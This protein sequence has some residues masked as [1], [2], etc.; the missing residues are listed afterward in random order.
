M[1][2]QLMFNNLKL[3]IFLW[4]YDDVFVIMFKK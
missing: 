3:L 4:G 2:D 1:F